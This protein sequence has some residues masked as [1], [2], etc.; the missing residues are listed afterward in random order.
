MNIFKAFQRDL[1]LKR[2]G[3]CFLFSLGIH[4]VL[5]ILAITLLSSAPQSGLAERV[6]EVKIVPPETLYLPEMNE[7]P[8]RVVEFD[9]DLRENRLKRSEAPGAGGESRSFETQDS[10]G[11]SRQNVDPSGR[12]GSSDELDFS[13]FSSK[14][15]IVVPRSKEL[16]WPLNKDLD[17][18]L[19]SDEEEFP[20]KRTDEGKLKIDAR[21]LQVPYSGLRNLG[22][23][24]APYIP[25][26][27]GGG[28]IR[29]F[30]DRT[31][32]F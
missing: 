6:Y 11:V 29:I 30:R 24:G 20:W 9:F 27:P 7:Y 14:F 21:Y 31:E 32:H 17:L 15:E 18:S 22:S 16:T 2:R 23:T 1:E 3:Y 10:T 5:Y 25:V 4:L 28:I 12:P 26:N 8:D 13:E 19:R